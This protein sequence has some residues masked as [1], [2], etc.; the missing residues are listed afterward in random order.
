MCTCLNMIIIL[1][2]ELFNHGFKTREHVMTN[3]M[4][5]WYWVSFLP[6]VKLLHSLF[7]CWVSHFLKKIQFKTC[8]A[9]AE[10]C[11]IHRMDKIFPRTWYFW[12]ICSSCVQDRIQDFFLGGGA[13][14]RNFSCSTSTS[15]N[16]IFVFC[17]IPVVLES[18]GSSRGGGG[19][20]AHPCTLPLDPPPCAANCGQKMFVITWST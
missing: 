15:I 8:Y 10:R 11:K 20:G 5:V 18:R 9:R 13:P 1:I 3:F 19:G 16:R 4:I 2:P 7:V 12:G 17:R 14:L 6:S